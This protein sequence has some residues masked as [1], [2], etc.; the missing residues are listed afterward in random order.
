M[1]KRTRKES[2]VFPADRIAEVAAI[3]A[4]GGAV[5]RHG[6]APRDV[7]DLVRPSTAI[8]LEAECRRA[9]RRIRAKGKKR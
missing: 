5:V 2:I 9:Q 7:Q 8:A 6:M 1:L 3:I 4:L